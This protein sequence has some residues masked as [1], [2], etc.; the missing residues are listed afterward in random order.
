MP[1]PNDLFNS[2]SSTCILV[3]P[4]RSLDDSTYGTLS[5]LTL[6]NNVE[7]VSALA[8]DPHF[9]QQLFQA[10]RA[11]PPGSET[12]ADLVA[13]LQVWGRDRANVCVY[14]YLL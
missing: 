10:L 9:L 3:C 4:C 12:W 5:S 8:G 6:F 14:W 13:F 2:V 11:A 7:V 1:E